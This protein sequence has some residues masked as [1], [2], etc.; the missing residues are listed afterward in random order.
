MTPEELAEEEARAERGAERLRRV[1]GHRGETPALSLEQARVHGPVIAEHARLVVERWRS[2]V[3]DMPQLLSVAMIELRRALVYAST[4]E[5]EDGRA[6][7]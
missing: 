1:F 4:M 3:G 7:P 6:S 5:A 2:T